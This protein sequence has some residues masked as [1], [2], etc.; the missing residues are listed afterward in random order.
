MTERVHTTLDRI[1]G[2]WALV[3]RPLSGGGGVLLSC[4]QQGATACSGGGRSILF[5]RARPLR[6]EYR[7][8]VAS[9]IDIGVI[10]YK[11][12]ETTDATERREG[13]ISFYN[14]L[15]VLSSGLQ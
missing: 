7:L 11:M 5:R 14:G 9:S 12:E 13:Q 10:Y 1:R 15:A 6:L 8:V 3:V 2:Q 4:T